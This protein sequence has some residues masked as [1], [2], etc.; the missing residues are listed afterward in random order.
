MPTLG[1]NHYNLRG[2]RALLE[3][4][5]AFYCEVVGLS[6]GPR[7]PFGNFGYWLYAGGQAVLHLSESGPSENRGT[8]AAS[9]FDHAAFNCSGRSEFE[10]KLAQRGL[11]FRVARVPQTGQMQLFLTD[12]AGNGVELNFAS[13][14][15]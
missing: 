8:G 7:P 11:S 3:E 4:L 6:V 5:R 12:P 1:L 10:S 13:E 9:T 14:D 15:A 2:P